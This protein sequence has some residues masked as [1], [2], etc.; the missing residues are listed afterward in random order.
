MTHPYVE[1]AFSGYLAYQFDSLLK[2]YKDSVT[3]WDGDFSP[4][5]WM[6][7]VARSVVERRLEGSELARLMGILDRELNIGR[8]GAG[9]L[10]GVAFIENLPLPSAGGGRFVKGYEA[11]EAQYK[12]VF[13]D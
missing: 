11:L 12:L 5:L 13:G 7:D 10:I 6:A 4:Y 2:I 8:S 1:M 3:D 9:N